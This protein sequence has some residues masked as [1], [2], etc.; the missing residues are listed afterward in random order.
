[1]KVT[2][3]TDEIIE[4]VKMDLSDRAE[5]DSILMDKE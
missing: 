3:N 2:V 4:T 5:N 1:V